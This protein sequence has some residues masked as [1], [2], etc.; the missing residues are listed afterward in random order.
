MNDLSDLEFEALPAYPASKEDFTSW[1]LWAQNRMASKRVPSLR[2]K[3]HQL[4]STERAKHIISWRALLAF[5]TGDKTVAPD[6]APIAAHHFLINALDAPALIVEVARRLLDESIHS[7]STATDTLF[8]AAAFAWPLR[9]LEPDLGDLAWDYIVYAP[10]QTDALSI[11]DVLL[12]VNTHQAFR[13]GR[14][15]IDLVRAKLDA[16][17]Q[18]AA[19]EWLEGVALIQARKMHLHQLTYYRDFVAAPMIQD[20]HEALVILAQMYVTMGADQSYARE[21]IKRA[22]E[23]TMSYDLVSVIETRVWD[24]TM[25]E[26]Y[27]WSE[28]VTHPRMLDDA[29]E[30][31]LEYGQPHH[32]RRLAEALL[33]RKYNRVWYGAVQDN[34]PVALER[35]EKQ[36]DR[37]VPTDPVTRRASEHLAILYSR[38]N[39]ITRHARRFIHTIVGSIAYTGHGAQLYDMRQELE[40]FFNRSDPYHILRAE[41]IVLSNVQDALS[42]DERAASDEVD[43]WFHDRFHLQNP[44]IFDRFSRWI[45]APLTDV[46]KRFTNLPVYEEVVDSALNVMMAYGPLIAGDL[47][48]IIRHAAELRSRYGHGMRLMAYAKEVT[49]FEALAAAGIASG[50]SFIAPGTNLASHAMDLGTS[51]LLIFRAISRVGAVFG[52]DIQEPEGF[53]LIADSLTVGFSSGE[54]EGLLSYFSAPDNTM[55]RAATIGGVTYG[56]SRL[57]EYMWTAPNQVG[58][59]ASERAIRHVARFCGMEL[60]ENAIARAVPLVGAII[61]G[62]STYAFMSKII[63]AAIHIAARDA[64]MVRANVY[65]QDF[66]PYLTPEM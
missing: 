3:V 62:M 65:E 1:S 13:D 60:S 27:R 2:I 31:A 15:V 4:E 55:L 57:V 50:T 46:Y 63:D 26:A 10:W 35:F 30:K 25:D 32:A 48:S 7:G 23:M 9:D 18:H 44:S 22:A 56:G 49:R 6:D 17:R 51:L 33:V 43:R 8:L 34:L 58:M 40:L 41:S 5:W 47:D 36:L 29:I 52:R 61:S 16:G 45:T 28:S 11:K 14:S 53:K 38:T 59:R 37:N 64:L 20:A 12:A 66:T 54:G 42:D 39:H 21:V 24:R 19:R